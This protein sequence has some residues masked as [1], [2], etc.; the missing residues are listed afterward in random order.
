MDRRAILI[1]ISASF[2]VLPASARGMYCTRH[3]QACKEI[4]EAR[5]REFKRRMSL[6]DKQREA[7]DA[8]EAKR[9]AEFRAK[10][11][12]ENK[13]I[14]GEFRSFALKAIGSFAVAVVALLGSIYISG[15]KRP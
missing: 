1:G 7:E 4:D 6:T 9:R 12:A 11:D 8:E 15:M 5:A 13:K 10:I 3:P 2:F 14:Q